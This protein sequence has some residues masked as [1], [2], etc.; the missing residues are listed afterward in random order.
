M[1][2][3]V[4]STILNMYLFWTVILSL[5]NIRSG[6]GIRKEYILISLIWRPD[7]MI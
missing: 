2:T 3:H 6:L 5:H 1:S 4:R 7:L